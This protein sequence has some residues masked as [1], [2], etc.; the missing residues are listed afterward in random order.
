M[1]RLMTLAVCDFAIEDKRDHRFTL[2]GLLDT[3]TVQVPARAEVPTDARAPKEWHCI[4]IWQ[5]V[6]GDTG[7]AFEQRLELVA[8]DGTV[9]VTVPHVF[10][11]DARIHRVAIKGDGLPVAPEGEYAF[12]VSVRAAGPDATWQPAG[13]YAVLVRHQRVDADHD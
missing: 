1:P 11:M 13:E 9:V 2:V 3:V 5:R 12:R 6:A 8:P 7:Q 4:A 10:Q